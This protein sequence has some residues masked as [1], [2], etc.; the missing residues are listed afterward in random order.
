MFWEVTGIRRELSHKAPACR[1]KHAPDGQAR[2][3]CGTET[4]VLEQALVVRFGKGAPD[5]LFFG[6]RA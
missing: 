6:F 2:D 1:F 4:R 3:A 5:P